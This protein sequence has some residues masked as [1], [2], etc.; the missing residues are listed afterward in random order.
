VQKFFTAFNARFGPHQ[1][2][3]YPV[4]GYDAA[5]AALQV[6][7]TPAVLKA[8]DAGNI[9]EARKAFRDGT[10]KLTQFKGLQGEQTASYHFGPQQHHGSPDQNWYVFILVAD[11]GTRLVKPDLSK[12][13]PL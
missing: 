2:T 9:E 8:I 4:I 5:K 12:F 1:P 7:A 11:N 13:K 3:L 6:I 10:E